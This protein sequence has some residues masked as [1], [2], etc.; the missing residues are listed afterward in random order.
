[1]SASHPKADILAIY[2]AH[3]SGLSAN[4][5]KI[6]FPKNL[7]RSLPRPFWLEENIN[8]NVTI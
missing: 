1:M 6:V 5:Q 7:S 3:K 4:F 2:E 8:G